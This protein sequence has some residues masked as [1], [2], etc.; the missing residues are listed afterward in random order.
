MFQTDKNSRAFVAL[1]SLFGALLAIW[2]AYGVFVGVGGL[3]G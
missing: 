3:G 2:V 1:A